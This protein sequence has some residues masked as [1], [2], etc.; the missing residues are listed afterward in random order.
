MKNRQKGAA[1]KRSRLRSDKMKA[2]EAAPPSM[3]KQI[4]ANGQD[5]ASQILET[6]ELMGL[7][8]QENREQA[9]SRIQQVDLIWDSSNHSWIMV[10]AEGLSG[11]LAFSWDSSFIELSSQ[12]SSRNWIWFHGRG[13]GNHLA[14][15]CCVNVYMPH[16]KRKRKIVWQELL[17][18]IFK[19][20]E[21]PICF[22]GDFNCILYDHDR[23]NCQYRSSDTV[24]LQAFMRDSGFSDIPI[25]R[26]DFTWFGPQGRCSRLDRAL[27]NHAWRASGDWSL[28]S[29]GRKNSDHS[30]IFLSQGSIDWGH[31]P[32]KVFNAWLDKEDFLDLIFSHWDKLRDSGKNIHSKFKSLRKVIKEWLRSSDSIEEMINKLEKQRDSLSGSPNHGIE[33]KCVEQQ[34][35]DAYAEQDSQLRQK[36][37]LN[38]DLIL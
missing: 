28:E 6:A 10:E 25:L 33:L 29:K 7:V 1:Q 9:L 16:K 31:K 22:I 4:L 35:L 14:E 32:F 18:L 17:A 11:G 34:L 26:Q 21:L 37:K 20:K 12:F 8:L 3:G 2:I 38:W 5:V 23:I 15:F 30:A 13:K 19:F 27:I 36:A 24:E